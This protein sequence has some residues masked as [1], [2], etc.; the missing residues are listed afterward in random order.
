ML[1][2]TEAKAILDDLLEE[3]PEAAWKS[4]YGFPCIFA[5]GRVFGLY[6]GEFIVLRFRPEQADVL[7]GQG[8]GV[9]LKG[10][11]GAS[12]RMAW[13]RVAHDRLAGPER[14]RELVRLSYETRLNDSAG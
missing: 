10:K 1:D 11:L 6:D 8:E 9:T 13:L 7:V 2:I 14:L 5:G 12:A 3:L 4:A